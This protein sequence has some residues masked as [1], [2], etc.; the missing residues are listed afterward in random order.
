[1]W[2]ITFNLNMRLGQHWS[3]RGAKWTKVH[4]PQSLVEVVY[5]ATRE[6]ENTVTLRYIEL[7]GKEKVR[8]GSWCKVGAEPADS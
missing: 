7:Y 3:G 5:P 1:M 4:R 2:G 8:G 6:L